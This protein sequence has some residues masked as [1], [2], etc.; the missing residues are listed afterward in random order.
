VKDALTIPEAVQRKA[1]AGGAAGVAW[2]AGLERTVAELARLWDLSVGPILPGGTEALVAEA[3]LSD[4]RAA[5]L[6]VYPPGV[7]L[8][9]GELPTLL[10]ARGRG[11][12]EVYVYDHPRAAA[13]LERLGPPLADLGLPVDAQLAIICATLAEAWAAPPAGAWC[14]TGA[15]KA[16]SLS[17]FITTTWQELGQPCS[18]QVIATARRY[19]DERRRAFDPRSAVLAHGDAHPWNTLLVPGDGPQRFKFVD[20]DGL[21]IERAYDLGISMREWTSELLAGD[22]VALGVQR[23]RRLA[24]RTGIDPEPIWQWGFIERV[25]TALLCLKVGLDGAREML[26]VAERW[27]V[28]R[29]EQL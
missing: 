22:P 3:T 15:E 16:G 20:P 26:T 1:L 24:E 25:S 21:F 2:L 17:D 4:G 8:D 27:A 28:G 14:M 29:P 11:Y 10:A 23:C 12:A 13:L 7:S 9:A 6:K 5:V 19:A 18:A